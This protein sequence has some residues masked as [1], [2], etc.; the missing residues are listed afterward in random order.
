MYTCLVR[1]AYGWLVAA[2]VLHFVVDVVSH[3]LRGV[4]E[5]GAETRLHDGLNSAFALGQLTFGLFGL[6][7]SW[8]APGVL[9]E[10]PLLPMSVVTGVAWLAIAFVFMEYQE[11]RFMVGVFCML[12]FGAW[13]AR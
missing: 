13:L 3:H 7:L 4:H 11:P 5:P 9:R 10:G 2:G 1:S 8:Q 12:V 6:L